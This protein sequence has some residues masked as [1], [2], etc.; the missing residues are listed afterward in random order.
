MVLHR[1]LGFSYWDAAQ[2]ARHLKRG[3]RTFRQARGDYDRTVLPHLVKAYARVAQATG[4]DFNPEQAARAELDWWV[5]R[6]DPQNSQ[7]GNVG[8]GIGR[9][10]RFVIPDAATRDEFAEAGRLRAEAAKLR[11]D[12]RDDP[13]W[14]GVERL[15]T[16]SYTHFRNGVEGR[17]KQAIERM[18]EPR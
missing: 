12:T 1:H 13:N 7:P 11:D 6:R 3:A 14:A 9:L 4:W 17:G 8:E 10:Y 15:L 18:E 5:A 16:Q 2:T